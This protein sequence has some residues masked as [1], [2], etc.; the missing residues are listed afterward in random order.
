[1]TFLMLFFV[2]LCVVI[3]PLI[4]LITVTES[5]TYKCTVCGTVGKTQTISHVFE[6]IFNDISTINMYKFNDRAR[7]YHVHKV[8]VCDSCYKK[9]FSFLVK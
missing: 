1:M 6:K 9:L 4:I 5:D 2:S 7:F 3:V 8:R